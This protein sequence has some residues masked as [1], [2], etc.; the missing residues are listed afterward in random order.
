MDSHA[1]TNYD[2]SAVKA[3]LPNKTISSHP[4]CKGSYS[5]K[6]IVIESKEMTIYAGDMN[7]N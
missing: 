7:N 4:T 5:L 3:A 1:P 2:A 6:F